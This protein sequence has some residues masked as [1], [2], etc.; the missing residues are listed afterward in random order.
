M[1]CDRII[2][3]EKERPTAKEIEL[4][5]RDF[6]GD[7]TKQIYYDKDRWFVLL[8][9]L[10]H[11]PYERIDIAT[12]AMKQVAIENR[13]NNKERWIEIWS[14]EDSVDVITRDAD[15]YT[16]TIAQGLAEVFRKFWQGTLH[17]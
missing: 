12:D 17:E 11:Q 16:N 6:F 10:Y 13:R 4:V 3:F 14:D 8:H 5:I 15:W 2:R 1:A 9:G 7:A